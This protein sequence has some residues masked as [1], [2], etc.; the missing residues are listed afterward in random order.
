MANQRITA[1]TAMSG[2]PDPESVMCGV[3]T[4]DTTMS[5]SGT[6]KKIQITNVTPTLGSTALT[7]GSAVTTV[8]GMESLTVTSGAGAVIAT[9]FTGA[10]VGDVT[11]V[12]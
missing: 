12:T 4:T 3:D 1:L 8:T 5:A 6:T 11:A 10:L 9:S 2:R 7:L